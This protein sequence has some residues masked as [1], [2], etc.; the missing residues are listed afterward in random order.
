M[1]ISA[2]PAHIHVYERDVEKSILTQLN[3]NNFIALET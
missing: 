1:Y 3:C 2:N